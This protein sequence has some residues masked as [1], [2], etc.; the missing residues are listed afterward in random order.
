MSKKQSRVHYHLD[1]GGIKTLPMEEIKMIL[2]AADDLITVGGRSSLA[3]V[4][5][6]SRDKKI[7]AYE[8]DKNPAYGFYRDL[9][10][11]EITNRVDW[12]IQQ[13]YLQLEYFG[14]LPLLVYTDK[15]WAIERETYAEELMQKL[16]KCMEERD[17]TF[18]TELKDRNR[19]MILLLLQKIQ[20]T[21]NARFIPLLKAWQEIEYKKVQSAIQEVIDYLVQEGRIY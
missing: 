1:S 14:R 8:L 18:V 12:M 4:L 9:T 10:V 17:Y 19:E 5:K 21:N 6:G 15:G 13:G 2:R 16:K 11:S 20:K 7:L 3:K